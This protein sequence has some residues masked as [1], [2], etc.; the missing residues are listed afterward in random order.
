MSKLNE[1]INLITKFVE[2][3]KCNKNI[4]IKFTLGKYTEIFGFEKNLFHEENYKKIMTLLDSC[5]EWEEIAEESDEKFTDEPE[6]ILDSFVLSYTG[7][8]YDIL[9]TAETKKNT[10]VYKSETY[11]EN[12][13]HYMRK[14]HIYSLNYNN[15]Q[16]FNFVLTLVPDVKTSCSYLAHSSILKFNDV[17]NCCG[18]ISDKYILKKI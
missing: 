7:S 3:Y 16:I 18:K 9:I 15:E 12:S 4:E 1:T 2:K 6:K 10:R 13:I 11:I 5:N 14:N 17:I 8:P